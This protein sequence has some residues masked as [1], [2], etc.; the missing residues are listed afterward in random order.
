VEVERQ[1]LARE[2]GGF[3]R[4]ERVEADI[5]VR[6]G[7]AVRWEKAPMSPLGGRAGGPSR[8][9]VERY[10]AVHYGP[11]EASQLGVGVTIETDAGRVEAQSQGESYTVG[12]PHRPDSTERKRRPK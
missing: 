9:E 12:E 1:R 7:R 6:G 4:I 8:D 10:Q 2:V 5:P 11:S 3:E